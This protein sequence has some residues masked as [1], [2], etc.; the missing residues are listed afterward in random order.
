MS[1]APSATLWLRWRE[2]PPAAAEVP[3]LALVDPALGTKESSEERSLDF[4][5]GVAL[6]ALPHARRE[7][8]AVLR[9]LGGGSQLLL[10]GDASE[11]AIKTSE[12]SRYGILHFA[13]HAVADEENPERSA[14]V[15]S[16]GNESEDGLLQVREIGELKLGGR[17]VVL[18][19][20]QTAAGRTLNG[21]GV[22]SL[23]RAFFQAGAHAVVASRWPLRDDEA[24]VL[25][26]DFYRAL[27]SGESL[28]RL[29]RI[30]TESA[31][32]AG[33]PVSAWSALSVYGD[34]SLAPI[35][36]APFTVE[37]PVSLLVVL[38]LL[39]ALTFALRVRSRRAG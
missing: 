33:L 22:Q 6:G 36:A 24:A 30:A 18:S 27:G 21:E 10:A 31:V 23:A 37:L 7:G 15:L 1:I 4:R 32:D 20:C 8:R 2:T 3:A 35:A 9:R 13:A 29:L 12:L 28:A 25:F 11:H 38:I 16:P 26:D 14:V 19:A 39:L 17:I 34:G 5:A